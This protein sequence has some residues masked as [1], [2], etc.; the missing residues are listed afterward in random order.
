MVQT[1]PA[2]QKTTTIRIK[3]SSTYTSDT[4]YCSS[5]TIA[6]ITPQSLSLITAFQQKRIGWEVAVR[7]A[8]I[9]CT[10]LHKAQEKQVKEILN[11]LSKRPERF[12][13]RIVS[14]II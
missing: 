1:T 8:K 4:L 2:K 10:V 6:N 12:C 9:L 5:H 11:I 3:G 14:T 7:K 13:K